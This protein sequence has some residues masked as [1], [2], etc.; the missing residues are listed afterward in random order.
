MK[1]HGHD[2]RGGN[3][4]PEARKQARCGCTEAEHRERKQ[5]EAL[6][7]EHKEYPDGGEGKEARDLAR[8][9]Q[10]AYLSP[11]E[12]GMLHGE[13][14]EQGLPRS[15]RKRAGGCKHGEQLYARCRVPERA[16]RLH[17]SLSRR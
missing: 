7:T 12:A 9:M 17:L 16:L 6:L 1:T 3:Q 8:R 5:G 15:E 11:V 2:H 13:V 10:G 4:P 14:V